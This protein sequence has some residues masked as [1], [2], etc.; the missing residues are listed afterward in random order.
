MPG[1]LL[2]HH[3]AHGVTRVKSFLN[4]AYHGT[5]KFLQNVDVYSG[6]FRRVLSA[7]Q[8]LLADLGVQEPTNRYAMQAVG[9][10]DQA[11][12]AIVGAHDK[13]AD[14]Y[15]RIAKAVG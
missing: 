10:Y 1:K 5:R 4:H 8:P 2:Q 14:N 12:S 11:K 6:M 9:A 7:A 3:I 15:A 13:A